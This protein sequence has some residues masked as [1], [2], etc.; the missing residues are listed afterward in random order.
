[1]DDNGGR[2]ETGMARNVVRANSE[3]GMFMGKKL[4]GKSRADAE[5]ENVPNTVARNFLI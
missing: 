3:T 2:K 5:Q 4:R 1:M